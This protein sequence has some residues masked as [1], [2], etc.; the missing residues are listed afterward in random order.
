MMKSIALAAVI[1][2]TG[3]GLA[4]AQSNPT[5]TALIDA[6]FNQIATEIMP[7]K[8]D[9]ST[10]RGTIANQATADHAFN[11]VAGRT[12][13]AIGVCD[14]GCSDLDMGVYSSNGE[15][16]GSDVLDDDTPIVQ[17]QAAQSGQMTIRVLMSACSA[18]RCNYGVKVYEQ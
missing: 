3:G 10:S 1:A 18:S 17:F 14:E 12:Y 8:K 7:G 5:G 13:V 15:T 9:I 11:A 2:L 4:A 6:L 16:L